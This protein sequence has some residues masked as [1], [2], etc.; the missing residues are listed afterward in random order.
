MLTV[1]V[2]VKTP[3]LDAFRRV[4]ATKMA[5]GSHPA[6]DAM[7][8]QWGKRYEG[9]ARRRFTRLSRGGGEWPPLAPSTIKR[10]RAG[11]GKKR[12]DLTRAVAILRDKGVLFSAMQIGTIGNQFHRIPMGVRYGFSRIPHSAGNRSSLQKIAGY[13]Q[14]GAGNLPRRTIVV[15]PDQTTLTGMSNDAGRMMLRVMK[16]TP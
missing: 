9:F 5:P 14:T 8:N 1:T 6:I 10:R 16:A 4:V 12:S 15:A 13:H 7:C 11:K 3:G 2:N